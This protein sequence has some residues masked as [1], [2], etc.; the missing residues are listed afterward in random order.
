ME[1]VLKE[2]IDYYGVDM[3]LNVAIEELSELIKE[4]CKYKRGQGCEM[5]I[6]EEMADVKIIL[7]ELEIIFN[8]KYRVESWYED[9]KE[10]LKWRVTKDSIEKG[11]GYEAWKKSFGE[12][13]E[14]TA[15]ART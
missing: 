15:E 2:A 5:H 7:E 10:R 9:K 6:A 13:E 4:L 12:T 1:N 8:N 14:G 11:R 3:Q